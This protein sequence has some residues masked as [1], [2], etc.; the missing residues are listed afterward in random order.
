VHRFD[1]CYNSRVVRG[2]G[3][4]KVCFPRKE[5][6]CMLGEEIGVDGLC[7]DTMDVSFNSKRACTI[8]I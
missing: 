7:L 4:C 5:L 1:S 3:E 2:E 8:A 6:G